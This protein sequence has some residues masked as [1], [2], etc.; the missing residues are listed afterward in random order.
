MKP[1]LPEE[2]QHDDPKWTW[3]RLREGYTGRA[4]KRIRW[5]RCCRKATSSKPP[6]TSTVGAAKAG[7]KRYG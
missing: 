6:T 1:N 3:R 5:K 2:D 4:A 7:S